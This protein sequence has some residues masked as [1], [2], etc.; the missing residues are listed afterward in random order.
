MRAFGGENAAQPGGQYEKQTILH[1]IFGNHVSRIDGVA[2]V[3]PNASVSDS[4]F[5]IKGQRYHLEARDKQ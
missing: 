2:V 3:W 4:I 1:S 5:K